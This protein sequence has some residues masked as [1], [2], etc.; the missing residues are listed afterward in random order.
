MKKGAENQKMSKKCKQLQNRQVQKNL[1]KYKEINSLKMQEN[2]PKLKNM[3]IQRGKKKK[4]AQIISLRE[5]E[6]H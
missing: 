6:K 2:S 3:K 4:A 1:M 5:L